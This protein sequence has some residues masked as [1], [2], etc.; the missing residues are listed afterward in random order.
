[1]E[2]KIVA[3]GTSALT[4]SEVKFDSDDDAASFMQ[5]KSHVHVAP[6]EAPETFGE[7]K[8]SKKS[9]GVIGLMDMMIGDLKMSLG[10]IKFGEKTAQTD[11][12]DLMDSSSAKRAQDGKS[13]TDQ[14]AGKADLLEA[15]PGQG[16]PASPHE[17]TLQY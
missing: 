8:K 5:I 1:M 7:F 10:E 3:A 12:V 17:R 2:D 6:P 9:G 13:L 4:Q 11:Y 14:E 16:V 15:Y